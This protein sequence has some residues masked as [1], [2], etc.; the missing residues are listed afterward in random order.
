MLLFFF[1]DFAHLANIGRLI[2]QQNPAHQVA[3][4]SGSGT[5]N[6]HKHFLNFYI[7][8]WV[9]A[10]DKAGVK[11]TAKRA[12]VRV[13]VWHHWQAVGSSEGSEAV[14][15]FGREAFVDAIV[16]WIVADN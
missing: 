5:D 2:R 12:T 10:C 14:R 11:I 7:D 13:E 1:D 4:W 8:V 3:S 15:N 9:P 16:E 6:L